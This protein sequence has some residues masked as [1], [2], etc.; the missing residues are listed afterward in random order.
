MGTHNLRRPLD[1]LFAICDPVAFD[2]LTQYSLVGE[3]LI[4]GLFL[5]QVW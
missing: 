2:L 5:C 3:L 4:D 1:R